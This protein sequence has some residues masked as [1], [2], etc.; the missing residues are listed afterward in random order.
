M[1]TIDTTYLRMKQF[2]AETNSKVDLSA[3]SVMNEWVL[4]LSAAAFNELINNDVLAMDNVKSIADAQA[5]LVDTFSE[6]IDKIASNYGITRKAGVKAAGTI[7]VVVQSA[8]SYFIEQGLR[9]VY[10]LLNAGFVTKEASDIAATD[11]NTEADGSAWFTLAVE[12]ESDIGTVVIAEDSGFALDSNFTIDGFVEAYAEAGFTAGSSTETD[13]ELISR[14]RD[15]LVVKNYSSAAAIK[16]KLTD[17]YSDLQAVAVVGSGD[18]ELLRGKNTS[19]GIS[20]QGAADIY[21]RHGFNIESATL[22]VVDGI[23]TCP[24]VYRFKAIPNVTFAYSLT[25]DAEEA[26]LSTTMHG[27][28]SKYQ[29]VTITGSET[30]TVTGYR[31]A[32][33]EAIQDLLNEP[34]NRQVGANYLVKGVVPCIVTVGLTLLQNASKPITDDV[35]NAIRTDIAT[36]IHALTFGEA[37]IASRLID[38]CHN[39]SQ[40]KAVQLPL[41]LQGDIWLPT[42]TVVCDANSQSETADTYTLKGNNT[43]TIPDNSELRA[44]GVSS[45]NTLFFVQLANESTISIQVKG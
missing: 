9:F 28:F 38:I 35:K 45:K 33:V 19:F 27:R 16:S 22:D 25:D 42:T 5:S 37:M 11:V 31:M 39:Y 4:K 14:F 36:Y 12:A 21:I 10:P 29:K 41:L 3:G 24:G 2:L 13:V 40:V 1:E 6:A 32:N 20:A 15:G 23:V 43:L 34:E 7:R 17:V 30:P 18:V 8:Q 44:Y 26:L